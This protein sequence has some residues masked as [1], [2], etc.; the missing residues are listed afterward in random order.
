MQQVTTNETSKSTKLEDG[1]Y[2]LRRSDRHVPIIQNL[3]NIIVVV[4]I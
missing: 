1:R 4:S 2:E 3:Q